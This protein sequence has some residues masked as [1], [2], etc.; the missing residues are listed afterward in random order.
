MVTQLV[1]KFCCIVFFSHEDSRLCV[2]VRCRPLKVD[3]NPMFEGVLKTA[4]AVVL[5][6]NCFSG[7]KVG[8][9]S[10]RTCMH[11]ACWRTGIE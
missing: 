10:A 7:C 9:G 2:A 3:E 5:A 1:P 11:A 4:S 8:F 6:R